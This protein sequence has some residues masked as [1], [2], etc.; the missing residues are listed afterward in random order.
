MREWGDEWMN[1]WMNVWMNKSNLHF[2]STYT[3]QH[4]IIA[5]IILIYFKFWINLNGQE[6]YLFIVIKTL[7]P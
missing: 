6:L 3:Q 2:L 5:I 7:I 4:R 1:E